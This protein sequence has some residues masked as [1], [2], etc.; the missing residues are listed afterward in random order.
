MD[1]SVRTAEVMKAGGGMKAGLG[2]VIW[3]LTSR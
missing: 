1:F 2:V 3:S